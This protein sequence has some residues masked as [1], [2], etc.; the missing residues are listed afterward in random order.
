MAKLATLRAIA[1]NVC[2]SF[3]SGCGLLIGVF[4]MELYGEIA[5]SDEGYL[6]LDFLNGQREGAEPSASLWRAIQL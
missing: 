5:R 6:M 2:D 1:H 3:S 4:E